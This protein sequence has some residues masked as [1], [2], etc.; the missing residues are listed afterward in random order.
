MAL[1]HLAAEKHVGTDVEIV[2][3]REIL[4]DRLDPDPAGVHRACEGDA[5]AVEEDL[6]LFCL[7]DAGDAF[8][9]RRFS[10]NPSFANSLR[11]SLNNIYIGREGT[12]SSDNKQ[13]TCM[14]HH[15]V[16]KPKKADICNTN[17]ALPGSD[18]CETHLY[19]RN[20][21]CS[22]QACSGPPHTPGMRFALCKNHGIRVQG[23][24]DTL[25]LRMAGGPV[26]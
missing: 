2:G 16:A 5:R 4:V 24:Q 17:P 6:A 9:E 13:R 1:L 26:Q 18:F 21:L 15:T 14:R 19:H 12:M 25:P 3:E 10:R 23:R 20:N 7:V 8:D 22:V 11:V